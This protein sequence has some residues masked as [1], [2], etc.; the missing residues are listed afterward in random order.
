TTSSY[1]SSHPAA[2]SLSRFVMILSTNSHFQSYTNLSEAVRLT[3]SIVA[4]SLLPIPILCA[5]QGRPLT[6]GVHVKNVFAAPALGVRIILHRPQTP[7]RGP[8]HRVQGNLAQVLV[9]PFSC[10]FN[11]HPIH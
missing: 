6:F 7:I 10:P 8:R 4:P 9:L 1:P 2:E 3:N 5:I 11:R